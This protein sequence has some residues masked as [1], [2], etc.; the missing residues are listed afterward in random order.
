MK[1]K[2]IIFACLAALICV[3]WFGAASAA[4]LPR[5]QLDESE[6]H[7]GRAYWLFLER[8]YW[9]AMSFLDQAL[10]ANIYLVDYYLLRGLMLSRIGNYS[11]GRESLGYHLEIHSLFPIAIVLVDESD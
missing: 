8:D 11:G 2:A 10:R 4:V 3:F 6:R 9:G 5:A 7:F 1:K